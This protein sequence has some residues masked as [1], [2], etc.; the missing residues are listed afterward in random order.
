MPTPMI[1]EFFEVPLKNF[2]RVVAL[3]L[4]MEMIDEH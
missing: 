1:D 4:Y 3:Y 2:Y